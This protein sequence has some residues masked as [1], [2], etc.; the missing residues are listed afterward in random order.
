MIDNEF[1]C[2]NC[3]NVIIP[4]PYKDGNSVILIC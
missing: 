2:N 1:I 4:G 3:K